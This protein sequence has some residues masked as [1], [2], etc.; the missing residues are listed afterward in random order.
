MSLAKTLVSKSIGRSYFCISAM[1]TVV[2]D[3]KKEE[4]VDN[5]VKEDE[6]FLNPGRLTLGVRGGCQAGHGRGRYQ[7][8]GR[9][10]CI[11]DKVVLDWFSNNVFPSEVFSPCLSSLSYLSCFRANRCIHSSKLKGT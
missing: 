8:E 4:V 7:G 6:N 2:V 11:Q 10:Q 5:V 3:D 9:R 1:V